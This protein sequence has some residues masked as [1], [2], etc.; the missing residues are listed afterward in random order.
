MRNTNVKLLHCG[1]ASIVQFVGNS[2]ARVEKFIG[3]QPR[4]LFVTYTFTGVNSCPVHAG[5][6]MG[7]AEMDTDGGFCVHDGVLDG[8]GA[9]DGVTLG[10]GVLEGVKLRDDDRDTD[11]VGVTDSDT[12]EE[13]ETDDVT[14]S[15][16]VRDALA[17]HSAWMFTVDT[18]EAILGATLVRTVIWTGYRPAT[19]VAGVLMYVVNG[20]E[21]P[22]SATITY[23]AGIVNSVLSRY[24]NRLPVFTVT[25]FIDTK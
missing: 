11:G 17:P 1:M 21:A 24:L 8:V 12:L 13:R 22:P 9:R 6:A 7:A 10:A 23:D 2:R 14:D 19:T 3:E 20:T 15:V 25:L 16:G 5:T 18:T 4:L